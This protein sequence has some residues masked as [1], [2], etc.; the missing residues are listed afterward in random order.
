V[1]HLECCPFAQSTRPE[2]LANLSDNQIADIRAWS[3]FIRS[4]GQPLLDLYLYVSSENFH[5]ATKPAWAKSL[6][7]FAKSIIPSQRRTVAKERT[8]YL[9]ISSL[10]LDEDEEKMAMSQGDQ[11]LLNQG[12]NL[13]ARAQSNSATT[14]LLG[15]NGTLR[16]ILRQPEHSDTFRLNALADQ[17]CQPLEEQLGDKSW[18][19]HDDGD[20]WS[21][22]CL[23]LGYLSLMLHA[24]VPKRWL[25]TAIKTRY[26]RLVQYYDRVYERIHNRFHSQRADIFRRSSSPYSTLQGLNFIFT[27][28]FRSLPPF[29]E[30]EI[31]HVDSPESSAALKLRQE[32]LPLF[33]RYPILRTFS[34]AVGFLGATAFGAF[35]YAQWNTKREEDFVVTSRL[36]HSMY[37]AGFGEAEGF[38]SVLGDQMALEANFER[39]KEGLRGITVSESKFEVE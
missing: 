4:K 1:E 9:G 37:L 21:V 33:K 23:A 16:N 39:E 8:A 5:E 36:S 7:W 14:S 15:R 6:P 31:T 29:F 11:S 12:M 20:P 19:T 18:L 17:F 28:L 35:G 38:L 26:P 22:D 24:D 25:A 34:V 3:D 13:S 32:Y 2:S 30:T 10:D 27:H